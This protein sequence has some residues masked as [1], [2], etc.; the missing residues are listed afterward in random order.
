LARGRGHPAPR[1]SPMTHQRFRRF[2]T[3]AYYK[4]QDIK[5]EM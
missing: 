1:E 4:D 2:N 3:S 5:N